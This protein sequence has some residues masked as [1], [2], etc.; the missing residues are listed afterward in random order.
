MAEEENQSQDTLTIF[1]RESRLLRTVQADGA[2]CSFSPQGNLVVV[3]YSEHPPM[4]DRITHKLNEDGSLGEVLDLDGNFGIIREKEVTVSMDMNQA[5]ALAR[6]IQSSTDEQK[7][8][9]EEALN[10]DS[11]N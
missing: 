6:L 3:F 5:A 4:P 7:R 2:T 11:S 10:D 9:I 8:M 1:Y